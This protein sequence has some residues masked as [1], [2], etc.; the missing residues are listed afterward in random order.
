MTSPA[1]DKKSTSVYRHMKDKDLRSV[2][3]ATNWAIWSAAQQEHYIVF[4]PVFIFPWES[5]P[6][7]RDQKVNIWKKKGRGG[8]EADLRGEFQEI[9]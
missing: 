2:S 1:K 5:S 4:D 7:C 6:T 3:C 9:V 8:V